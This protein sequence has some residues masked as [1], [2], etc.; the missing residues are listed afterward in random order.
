VHCRPLN[1]VGQRA[2][3]PPGGANVACVAPL[4]EVP[5]C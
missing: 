3:P 2:L 1:G 5:Q 4:A